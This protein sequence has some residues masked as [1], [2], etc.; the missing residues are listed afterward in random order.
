MYI[1]G[2]F[3]ILS[4]MCC[5][6]FWTEYAGRLLDDTLSRILVTTFC[7]QNSIICQIFQTTTFLNLSDPSKAF[8]IFHN[9]PVYKNVHA[10]VLTNSGTALCPS[11]FPVTSKRW[12][13]GQLLSSICQE[14]HNS[15]MALVGTD[16]RAVCVDPLCASHQHCGINLWSESEQKEMQAGISERE[17]DEST[18]HRIKYWLRESADT[19]KAE[20]SEPTGFSWEDKNICYSSFKMPKPTLCGYIANSITA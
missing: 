14:L 7:V 6:H 8:S 16:I 10:S 11:L 2:L 5:C 18:L 1:N 9:L 20:I 19:A 3:L 15:I 4:K 13:H 12:S 17:R